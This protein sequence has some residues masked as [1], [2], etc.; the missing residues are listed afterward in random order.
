[1]VALC[2]VSLALLAQRPVSN[3]PPE[4]VALTSA[5]NGFEARA[6]RLRISDDL[7]TQIRKWTWRPG[8]PVPPA[9]LTLLRVS[10]WD[11]SGK[12]QNGEIVVN[13]AVADDL[14]SIFSRL[15]DHGFLV[16]RMSPVENYEGS[17]NESM[18]ANNTS[19][20]N[21]RDV[22]GQPGK[23]SNHSWGRAI[24]INPL[25]NP[26]ILHGKPLPPDGARYTDRTVAHP[27]SILA[28]SFIVKLFEEHGWT[29]GGTWA[30]PDYQHFE[31]PAVSEVLPRR[32][33]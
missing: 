22:T 6:T 5:R 29:W 15:F 12:P 23:F 33:D 25:T 16:E 31:K 24:D 30:N 3:D 8:C 20:F 1:V 4:I 28:G 19:A 9:D 13:R 27:G 32:V 17:D 10:Y 18:D 7:L 11:F 21:C 26:M 14:E 2:A